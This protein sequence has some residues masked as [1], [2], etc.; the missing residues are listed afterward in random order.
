M[1]PSPTLEPSPPLH[2][3]GS[4][5]TVC[6]SEAFR[7]TQTKYRALTRYTSAFCFVPSVVFQLFAP[8]YSIQSLRRPLTIRYLRLYW[9][10]RSGKSLSRGLSTAAVTS[11]ILTERLGTASMAA[12]HRASDGRTRCLPGQGGTWADRRGMTD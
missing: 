8:S 7:S 11:L 10:T 5:S 6:D 12:S 9:T 1:S 2:T 4:A 3:F